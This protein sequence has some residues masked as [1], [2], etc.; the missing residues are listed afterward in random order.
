LVKGKSTSKVGL[1]GDIL[2]PWRVSVYEKYGD[3]LDLDW[4]HYKAS[5]FQDGLL[6]CQKLIQSG[7]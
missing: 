6:A 2:V 1:E 4:K 3:N 7:I 5:T